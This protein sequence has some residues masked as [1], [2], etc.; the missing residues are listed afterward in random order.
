MKP[1][2]ALAVVVAS[3]VWVLGSAA[4]SSRPTAAVLQA[5]VTR[6][7]D[8]NSCCVVE[9]DIEGTVSIPS[10][11]RLRFTGE[12][13]LIAHYVSPTPQMSGLL[14]LTLVSP[15]GDSFGITGASD[16]F[17]FDDSPPASPWTIDDPTGRFSNLS[18]SGSYIVSG[19]DTGTLTLSFTGG[20]AKA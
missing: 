5:T 1:V 19:L 4:G 11:G 18:G 9:R 10:L 14:N 20:I 16:S 6:V 3:L 12:Y 13:D 15:S 2:G 8:A 7:W 17:G